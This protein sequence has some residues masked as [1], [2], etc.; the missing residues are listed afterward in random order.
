M[1]DEE[2]PEDLK[3]EEVNEEFARF[4]KLAGLNK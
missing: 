1:K 2:Y 4:A 3:K